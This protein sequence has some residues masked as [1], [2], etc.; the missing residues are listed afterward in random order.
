MFLNAVSLPLRPVKP[1]IGV[2]PP[3]RVLHPLQVGGFEARRWGQK[4]VLPLSHHRLPVL[5]TWDTAV[6]RADESPCPQGAPVW[7]ENQC[8]IASHCKGYFGES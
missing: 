1:A 3:Q 5:C 4:E 7:V 8:K 2:A 6:H